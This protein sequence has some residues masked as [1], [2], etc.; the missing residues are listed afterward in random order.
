MEIVLVNVLLLWR[1]TMTKADPI[2][3]KKKKKRHLMGVG[4]LTVSEV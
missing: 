2:K 1:D 3:K 4:L